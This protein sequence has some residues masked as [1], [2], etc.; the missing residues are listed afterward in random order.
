MLSTEWR[1]FF[2]TIKWGEPSLHFRCDKWKTKSTKIMLIANW[3]APQNKWSKIN[4]LSSY[5]RSYCPKNL[6]I[7]SEKCWNEGLHTNLQKNKFPNRQFYEI[8]VRKKYKIQFHLWTLFSILTSQ[9]SLEKIERKRTKSYNKE[10]SQV[11]ALLEF[12]QLFKN[13]KHIRE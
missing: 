10:R 5:W 2:A 6:R 9:S 7:C 1:V 11:E 3:I 8:L 13:T 12:V 4:Q